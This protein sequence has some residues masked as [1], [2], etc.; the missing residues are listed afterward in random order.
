MFE[1]MLFL[2]GVLQ[3]ARSYHGFGISTLGLINIKNS[4][5]HPLPWKAE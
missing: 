3:S 4:V 1:A 2:K 5:T